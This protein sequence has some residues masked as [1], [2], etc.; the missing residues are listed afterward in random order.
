MQKRSNCPI[1]D[2]VYENFLENLKNNFV[3]IPNHPYYYF[4]PMK[5]LVLSCKRTPKISLLKPTDSISYNIEGDY[6]N[7]TDLYYMLF[8]KSKPFNKNQVNL[9]YS[10]WSYCCEIFNKIN[11]TQK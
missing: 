1:N 7:A 4:H 6:Y 3:Q 5:G 10:Y 11:K 9:F 2:G 8:N